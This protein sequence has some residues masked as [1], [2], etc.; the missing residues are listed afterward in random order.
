MKS[1]PLTT[2]CLSLLLVAA[3]LFQTQFSPLVFWKRSKEKALAEIKRVEIGIK[4]QQSQIVSEIDSKNGQAG[5]FP[6][7][8]EASHLVQL[9]RRLFFDRRLSKDETISCANCH[10]PDHGWSV[11]EAL[12]QGVDGQRAKRHP[13]SLYNIAAARFLSWDGRTTSLEEQVLLPIGDRHEMNLQLAKAVERL[14][15]SPEYRQMFTAAGLQ[16]NETGLSTALAEFCRTIIAMDSPFDRFRSGDVEALSPA[17][18]RGHDLFFF[19]L[20]CGTCHTGSQLTDGKF[21][22]LGIGMEEINPDLGRFTVTGHKEDRGAFKTPS[23]RNVS[24]TAPYMHD[25]RFN[26]LEDVVDCY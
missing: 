22:N 5:S 3:G 17:A 11:A 14:Q 26:W 9:G 6:A 13:P 20:N 2:L 24:K 12:P 16:V 7:L 10:A 21:H 18:R 1:I 25:G 19:R 15:S 8:R 4:E 23:L